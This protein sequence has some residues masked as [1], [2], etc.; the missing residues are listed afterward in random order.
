M[1]SLRRLGS[2]L[3]ENLYDII[4]IFFSKERMK[5]LYGVSLYRNAGYLMLNSIVGSPLGFIFWVVV[6]RLY[7]TTEV[8]LVSALL[9]IMGLLNYLSS[10]GFDVGMIRFL[11]EEKDRSGMINSCLT[12]IGLAVAAMALVF[13]AATPLF[14]PAV[15]FV[16]ERPLYLAIFVVLAVGFSLFSILSSVFVALRAAHFSFII[17]MTMGVLKIVLAILLVALGT[18]GIFSAWGLAALLALVIGDLFLLRRGLPGYVP[19]PALKGGIVKQILGYSAGNYFA[20]L[21]GSLPTYILPIMIVNTLGAEQSAYF[22]IAYGIAIL[23]WTLPNGVATA[24]FAEGANKPEELRANTLKAIKFIF[25]IIT[26]LLVF[27]LVLGDKVLWLFGQQYSEK[28]FRLLQLLSL[29]SVPIAIA[30]LYLVTKRVSREVRPVIYLYSAVA[31]L[32]LGACFGFMQWF[33]IT[34]VGIGWLLGYSAVAVVAGALIVKWLK[35]AE[36]NDK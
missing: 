15:S 18:M 4:K 9:A 16:L 30:N 36:R 14:S 2:F 20:E 8:G 29:A 28:A 23:L 10:F 13:M 24:L 11:P 1:V 25:L 31:T 21:I 35:K 32:I 3:R 19:R 6:A 33:A 7:T 22:R 34:G 17:Q 26:P 27:I 5:G 12:I